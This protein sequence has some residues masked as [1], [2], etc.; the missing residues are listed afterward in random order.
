MICIRKA[1]EDAN[2][3]NEMRAKGIYR[4]LNKECMPDTAEDDIN[5]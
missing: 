3:K 2:V 5:E 4:D 1:E